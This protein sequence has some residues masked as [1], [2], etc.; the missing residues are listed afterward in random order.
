[1]F[2]SFLR[3]YVVVINPETGGRYLFGFFLKG[4]GLASGR[5]PELL[6]LRSQSASP[7]NVL[8]VFHQPDT[9]REECL[10]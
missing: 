2:L 8:V 3:A 6:Q 5:M 7:R 4:G 10:P 9:L 1:M